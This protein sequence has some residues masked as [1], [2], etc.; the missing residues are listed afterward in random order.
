M[1]GRVLLSSWWEVYADSWVPHPGPGHQGPVQL[2]QPQVPPAC[3]PALLDLPRVPDNTT[4]ER[5]RHLDR[6]PGAH[7][8]L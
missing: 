5:E 1:G 3:Q 2:L 4:A 7:P 6:A 8:Y